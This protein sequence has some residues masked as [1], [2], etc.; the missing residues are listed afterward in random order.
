MKIKTYIFTIDCTSL[1]QVFIVFLLSK[2][3]KLY[4]MPS[5]KLGT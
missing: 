1:K 3:V 4:Q 2:M 5:V